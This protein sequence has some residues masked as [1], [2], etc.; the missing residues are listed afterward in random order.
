[1]KII[2]HANLP[3]YRNSGAWGVILIL[4]FVAFGFFGCASHVAKPVSGELP[5][6]VSRLEGQ[7][8]WKYG[9]NDWQPIVKNQRVH[10]GV[11]IETAQNSLVELLLIQLQAPDQ[12]T[13]TASSLN[14]TD[15]RHTEPLRNDSQASN[16]SA[17]HDLMVR[18]WDNTRLALPQI[19]RSETKLRRVEVGK[20]ML[21]LQAGHIFVSLSKLPPG[22]EFNVKM[23]ECSASVRRAVFDANVDGIVKVL[24]GSVLVTGT[25]FSQLVESHQKF[26]ARTRVLSPLQLRHRPGLP[27]TGEES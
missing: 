23:P 27:I 22:S 16:S 18:I 21:D 2:K 6:T 24:A 17:G 13:Q 25:N 10:A 8:R 1:M 20:V 19:E 4:G 9:A 15:L 7:A 3:Q 5:L 14:R 12:S 11:V 26:D